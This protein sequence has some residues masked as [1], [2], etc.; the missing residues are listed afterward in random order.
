M[1]TSVTLLIAS[2][3]N[4]NI[5]VNK[6]FQSVTPLIINNLK[7]NI[8]VNVRTVAALNEE[9]GGKNNFFL[10]PAGLG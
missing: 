9:R 1:S 5:E 10:K 8:I 4:V 6:L 3:L 7:S 2:K